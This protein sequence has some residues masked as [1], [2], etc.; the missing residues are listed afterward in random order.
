MAGAN[1]VTKESEQFIGWYD[2]EIQAPATQPA[3]PKNR[4]NYLSPLGKL[5]EEFYDTVILKHDRGVTYTPVAIVLD[6]N[7]GNVLQYDVN[8]T[9]GHVP[10]GEGDYQV[11]ALINKLFPWEDYPATWNRE[12]MAATNGPFGDIFDVVTSDAPRE[13]LDAYRVL[14]LA[15]DVRLDSTGESNLEAFVRG[16]GTVLMTTEQMTPGLWRLSGLADGGKYVKAG[17]NQAMVHR[18]DGWKIPG[19]EPAFEYRR[20]KLISAEPLVV[21]EGDPSGVLAARNHLGKGQV[22]VA[23]PKWMVVPGSKNRLLGLFDCLLRDLVDDLLPVKVYGDIQW[24]LNRNAAGW[25]VTLIN[26]KGVY[27]YGGLP[28]VVRA[29]E[30]APVVL[31]PR[32]AWSTARE[33]LTGQVPAQPSVLVPPGEVRIVE[34]LTEPGKKLQKLRKRSMDTI[35]GHDII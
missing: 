21:L 24:M 6:R 18:P 5:Y 33:W 29:E 22:V 16:G 2:E 30:S 26:N 35:K 25:V 1:L 13:V 19:L 11:R 4:K 34:W 9:F 3:D 8:H 28:P 27:K 32:F 12:R 15:G 17:A 20:V 31:V 14:I 23:T 10:Y 7:H